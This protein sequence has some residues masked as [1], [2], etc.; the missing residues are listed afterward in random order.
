NGVDDMKDIIETVARAM[1][2]LD[3]LDETGEMK[4]RYYSPEAQA[5]VKALEAAG[6]A[7]VPVEPTKEQASKLMEQVKIQQGITLIYP[8]LE[9]CKDGYRAAIKA[10]ANHEAG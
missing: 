3:P 10:G 7:I 9:Q 5:A 1:W 4:W 2:K 8:S 6:Y